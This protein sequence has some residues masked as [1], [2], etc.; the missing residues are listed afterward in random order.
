MKTAINGYIYLRTDSYDGKQTFGWHTAKMDSMAEYATVRE[1]VLEF[2]LPDDISLT[3]IKIESLRKQ[4]AE[5]MAQFNQRVNQ[6]RD[7]ISK[8]QALECT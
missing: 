2:D 4:E 6:I 7:N 3:A 5:L 1:H 8:L